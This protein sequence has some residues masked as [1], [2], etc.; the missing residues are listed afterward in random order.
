MIKSI[1][2]PITELNKKNTKVKDSL[3]GSNTYVNSTNILTT[4]FKASNFWGDST[5]PYLS[6]LNYQ[7][8]AWRFAFNFKV[9]DFG[10]PSTG[11]Y[12][13]KDDNDTF[14]LFNNWFKESGFELYY[15]CESYEQD[16]DLPSIPTYAG[17]TNIIVNTN[18]VPSKIEVN[19]E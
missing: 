2:I 16:I 15:P 7:S 13:K 10:E 18:I 17:T 6:L 4:H 14:K 3:K 19:Y 12:L 8:D 5:T 9:T 11:E 1:N